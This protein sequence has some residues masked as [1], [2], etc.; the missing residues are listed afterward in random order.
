MSATVLL[1]TAPYACHERSTSSISIVL[2]GHQ[3]S[4]QPLFVVKIIETVIFKRVFV[5]YTVVDEKF[6]ALN[7]GIFAE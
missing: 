2:S 7:I 4:A 3:T 5:A 6:P 1:R